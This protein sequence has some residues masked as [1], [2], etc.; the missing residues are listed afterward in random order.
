MRAELPYTLQKAGVA[1]H[2]ENNVT[3]FG[4]VMS[5]PAGV[6][7]II[8]NLQVHC[9]GWVPYGN[10]LAKAREHILFVHKFETKVVSF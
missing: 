7:G 1:P 5:G 4:V 3:G 9:L 2:Q 8:F 6:M 10:L